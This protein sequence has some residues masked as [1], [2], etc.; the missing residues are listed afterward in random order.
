MSE[1]KVYPT[2]SKL[3]TVDEVASTFKVTPR[4]IFRWLDA[5]IIPK[6]IHL[7]GTTRF[8]RSEIDELVENG[9]MAKVRS[10]KR[11]RRR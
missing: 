8:R 2:L 3:M 5:G 1:P 7:G 6:P 9:S 4:T 10:S 11:S